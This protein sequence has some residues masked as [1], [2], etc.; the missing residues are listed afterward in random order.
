MKKS[1]ALFRGL[2]AVL[3][4]V[5][6]L[7][8][9]ATTLTFEYDSIINKA[10]GIATSVTEVAEDADADEAIYWPNEYGYDDAALTAVNLDAAA[11]NVDMEAESVVLLRNKD[12]ALPLSKGDRIT[13]FGNAATRIGDM[14]ATSVSFKD[15][16]TPASALQEVFGADNVNTALYDQLYSGMDNT[17][18][19]SV[20]EA[21]V[22]ELKKYENT[23]AG[24]NDTALVFLGRWAREG[25]DLHMYSDSETYSDGSPRRMLDLSVNEQAMIEYLVEQ[26][27]AGA[28][29][30]IVVVFYTVFPMEMDFLAEYDIDAAVIAGEP[31]DFGW[32]GVAQVLAGDVNPSGHTV[33]IFASNSVSAPA[34]TYAGYENTK[35]WSNAAAINEAFPETNDYEGK[36]LDYYV[37]YAEGIYV[38]YK[39]YET[40]YEDTVMGTG[41]ASSSTG[42]STGDAWDYPSEIDYPFG[43]G[44][45][46]TTFRQTLDS[47]TYDAAQQQYVVKVTVTNTGS[48]AGKD[49]VQV[50][51]QTPYGDY[52]KQNQ[53]EKAS[54][55]LMAYDKT[56]TLAPGGSQT[57]EIPVK[58]YFLASY[59]TYGAGTYI[60]SAGDY[61]LA[62]GEDSHDALNNILVAKGYTAANGMT[63][64]GDAGKTYTWNQAALDTESCR[65]SIYTGAE[66]SNQFD[67]A[68]IRSYGYEFTYL[69]R[70][71]WEGTFPVEGLQL[72]A[73]AAV[74]D[75]LEDFYYEE[76]SDAP[77]VD[78]FTTGQRAGISLTE[79]MGV[80]LDDPK[81]DDFVD[82]LTV[83]ELCHTFDDNLTSQ[84]VSDLDVPGTSHID[85]DQRGGG[86]FTFVYHATL[87]CSWNTD[88]H[89]QRGYYQGII[90]QLN[91]YNEL[92]YGA[93]DFHRTPFGGRSNQYFS[94]DAMLDYYAA[95]HEAAGM[96][97][98]G[99]ICCIKHFVINDQETNREGL[100]T[101]TNEQALRE[102]YLRAFEGGFAGGALSTMCSLGRVGTKLAKNNYSL[103]TT[104][105]RGEWGFQG[106]VTS[107]GWLPFLGYF[108]NTREMATAG[109]DYAC[110]DSSGTNAGRLIEY[111][112]AGDG[113]VL[114]AVH[115]LAK[116]NLYVMTQTSRMNGL[117]NGITVRAIVPT[118]EKALMVVNLVSCVGF[119]A[120]TAVSVIGYCKKK[121][122]S[123]T[124]RVE[125]R[126]A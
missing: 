51:A 58:R 96:Q 80:P 111:I 42:S 122:D 121:S 36:T 49:V 82:Q 83:E 59:D 93:C 45:S 86:E 68:D 91:N 55:A 23:W 76:P 24:G 77:S 8:V 98:V 34:C 117:G 78:S 44:G 81:W 106:H 92:W 20:S 4:V 109:M 104:V 50:Y 43:Y 94:S 100:S 99:T 39:Y 40:R 17:S 56:D 10:L 124:V 67:D 71:D 103:L 74:F 113:N 46:Y 79:M 19:S 7:S 87:A 29:Q 18:V 28:I 102:I 115:T 1:T 95:Y 6:L 88:L 31:G 89:Y 48:T 125:K 65:N 84:V 26:R 90:A 75:G 3:A 57:M 22:S 21:P 61:Y 32:L 105:L 11:A 118:W 116:R 112:N 38:G 25:N 27:A 70:N 52:E 53:V 123:D 33:E 126:E 62:I 5:M 69:S 60:L 47:V 119:V 73:S 110:L 97:S 16:Y 63:A 13:I 72:E 114:Q 12:N 9:T 30:K 66:I 41:N 2:A 85:D 37:I 108:Q 14:S 101:F 107:D 54:V 120:F 15:P 35:T 64:D